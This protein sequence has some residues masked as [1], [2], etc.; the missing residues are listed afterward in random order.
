MSSEHKHNSTKAVKEVSLRKAIRTLIPRH[1]KTMADLNGKADASLGR[2]QEE[3]CHGYLRLLEQ[4]LDSCTR[5][6]N[7]IPK[8]ARRNREPAS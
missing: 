2:G 1:L 3:R 4:E 6:V 7:G 5:L 8:A